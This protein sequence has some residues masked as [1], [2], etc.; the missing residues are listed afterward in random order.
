MNKL[1][2]LIPAH[3]EAE[4][5]PVFLKELEEYKFDKLI[6]LQKEDIET[7]DSISDLK[8]IKIFFQKIMDMEMPLK[9]VLTQSKLNFFV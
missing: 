9:K 4:S 5:L 8:D 2:L 6:V 1:T 7:I 3:K